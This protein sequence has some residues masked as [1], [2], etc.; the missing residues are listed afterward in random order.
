LQHMMTPSSR[1]ELQVAALLP[2]TTLAGLEKERQS[3]TTSRK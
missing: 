3:L 2:L 1:N